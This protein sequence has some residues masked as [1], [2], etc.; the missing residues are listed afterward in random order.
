MLELNIF[1]KELGCVNTKLTTGNVN[2]RLSSM[3][4]KSILLDYLISE[5]MAN[6][7][8]EM[9]KPEDNKALSITI[10]SS[11]TFAL[12]CSSGS[13]TKESILYF[14]SES[15]TARTLREMLTALRFQKP[16]DNIAPDLLFKKLEA[17]VS[18][19]LK[20]VP[21]ELI[22]KPMFFGEL[23]TE[24]WQKLDKVQGDLNEEYTIRREMLLK[25]LDV[26]VQSFS[27]RAF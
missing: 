2:H 15:I 6:K 1:L 20:Q 25:R 8:L 21:K 16:P 10:V 14:Q 18:E 12:Y 11:Y 26:T 22:G 5:L 23:S 4:D 7:M 19:V 13:S 17:K 24:Q 27:V 9:K 3:E